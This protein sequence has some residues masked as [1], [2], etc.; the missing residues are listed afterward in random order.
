[1]GYQ[2]Q[3]EPGRYEAVVTLATA[4]V[5]LIG[6]GF[7]SNSSFLYKQCIQKSG[8]ERGKIWWVFFNRYAGFF[9]F[10]LIPLGVIYILFSKD[11]TRYGVSIIN[12]AESFIWVLALGT[13][14][15]FSQ[16]I[17]ARNPVNLDHYPQIR[18]PVW[19]ISLIIKNALMWFVYLVSYEFMFRGFLL[20]GTVDIL[21][22][23]LAILVNTLIYSLTHIPKGARET[24]LAIPFGILICYLT[25][26]TGTIWVA[27][28]LHF[29]LA[30]SNDIFSLIAHPEMK[31]RR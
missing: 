27:V 17:F 3:W 20:F 23:W 10:L 4:I 28:F 25:L 19:S 21:G 1:M 29:I 11:I 22:V 8:E 31:I 24:I 18:I 9:Y 26:K 2:L 13:V 5:C 7:T 15:I 14:I 6:Y 30:V 16:S 12:L